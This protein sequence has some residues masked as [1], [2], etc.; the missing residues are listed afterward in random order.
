MYSPRGS[1]PAATSSEEGGH[2]AATDI[3]S[4]SRTRPAWHSQPISSSLAQ[5]RAVPICICL[6]TT[7]TVHGCSEAAG[8]TAGGKVHSKVCE[9]VCCC[10][11][12]ACQVPVAVLQVS[13]VLQQCCIVR[14][15][16]AP[17]TG[18]AGQ[19]LSTAG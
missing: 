1:W 9:L 8:N 4:C 16:L 14:P 5:H 18:L 15:Q 2:I 7:A 12:L 19:C 10:C 17:S 13:Q 6:L 11:Q 3:G